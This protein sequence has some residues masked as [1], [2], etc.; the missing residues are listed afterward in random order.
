[1]K[2]W[3]VQAEA[4]SEARNTAMRATSSGASQRFRHCA[5]SI[6]CSA[7]GVIQS[8]T[9]RSVRIQPGA[10]ALTRMLWGP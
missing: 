2:V 6:C 3:L 10:M 4:S 9:C 5:A 7:S 8:A 1:M